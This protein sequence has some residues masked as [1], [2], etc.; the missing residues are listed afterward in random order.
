MTF[1]HRRN[2]WVVEETDAEFTA[3]RSELLFEAPYVLDGGSGG[4]PTYDVSLD[5][6]QF[7]MVQESGLADETAGSTVVLNWHQELLERVPVD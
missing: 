1:A 6:E 3:G 2:L 4:N 5:G 7:L